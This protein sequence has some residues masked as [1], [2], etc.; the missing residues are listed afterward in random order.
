MRGLG[1]F[2]VLA[3]AL[4]FSG[5]ALAQP[6]GDNSSFFVTYYSNAAHSATVPDGTVRAVNDGDT[7][8]NLWASFYTFDDSQEMEEC[9]SC[10]VSQDGL[11]S[12]SVN[13]NLAGNPLTGIL[14]QRGLIKMISS[15]VAA[16]GPVNYT[17]IPTPGLRVWSTHVQ[18]QTPTAGAYYTTE[19]PAADS[20]LASE[21]EWM[22]ETLCFYIH[23]FGHESGQGVC[24][25]TPEDVDF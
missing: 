19:A 13:S 15:S 20:N 24:S 12:E 14:S 11:L 4:L 17:N 1:L 21:E 5:T 10:A 6:T 22:L 2:P 25:C 3:T 23:L 8:A 16:Q 9:C 18:R 7:G